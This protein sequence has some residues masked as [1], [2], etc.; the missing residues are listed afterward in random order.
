MGKCSGEWRGIPVLKTSLYVGS[1]IS[2]TASSP[3]LRRREEKIGKR[4][5]GADRQNSDFVKI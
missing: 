4:K 1:Q 2:E 3:R 5:G